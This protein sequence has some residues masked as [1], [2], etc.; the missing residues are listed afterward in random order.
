LGEVSEGERGST[1]DPELDAYLDDDDGH[2]G[3]E[4]PE[5][6]DLEGLDEHY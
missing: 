4:G 1:G 6:T 2:W 3:E 5:F